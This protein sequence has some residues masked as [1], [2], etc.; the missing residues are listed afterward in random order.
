MI[1]E[2]IYYIGQ[3][4]ICRGYGRLEIDKDFIDNEYLVMCE[5]CLAEWKTPQ[6][7]LNNINGRRCSCPEARVRSA[8]LDEIREMGWEKFIVDT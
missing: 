8:S 2:E 7:A 6:D 4:P 5:E 1:L 3:C